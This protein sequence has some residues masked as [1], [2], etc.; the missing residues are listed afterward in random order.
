MPSRQSHGLRLRPQNLEQEEAEPA[1]SRTDALVPRSRPQPFVPYNAEMRRSIQE[2][3]NRNPWMTQFL[4][5]EAR[6][7]WL[8]GAPD[9]PPAGPSG[10]LAER[11]PP[12][13]LSTPRPR[14]H[15]RS[16]PPMPWLLR[17]LPR[18][19]MLRLF[20]RL[21]QLM[22]LRQ[23]GWMPRPPQHPQ[24]LPCL[25]SPQREIQS[26]ANDEVPGLPENEFLQ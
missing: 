7:G 25:T 2:S 8:D 19:R 14:A 23:D 3:I 9:S 6:R 13:P 15:Q 12:P 21:R 4:T 17:R 1:S 16:R 10:T 5:L 26:L 11:P 24:L 22:L 18:C 20:R